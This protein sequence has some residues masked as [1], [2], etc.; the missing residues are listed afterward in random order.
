MET[1]TDWRSDSSRLALRNVLGIRLGITC[2]VSLPC[3]KKSFSP[4]E[5]TGV[6]SLCLE[7]QNSQQGHIQSESKAERLCQVFTAVV[8][9]SSSTWKGLFSYMQEAHRW[10]NFLGCY[11]WVI[12]SMQLDWRLPTKTEGDIAISGTLPSEALLHLSHGM[13]L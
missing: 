10:R 5:R 4:L 3:P 11:K 8:R 7:W 12:L 6:R 9:P 1:G 13:V 2:V